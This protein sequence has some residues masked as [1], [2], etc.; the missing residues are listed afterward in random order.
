MIHFDVWIVLPDGGTALAGELVCGDA[1]SAGRF[2][3]EF[4]YAADWLESPAFPLDPISLP[5]RSGPFQANKLEPPL[6]VFED[7]LPDDWGRQLIIR[8]CN[9]LAVNRA[10]PTCCARWQSTGS[11]LAPCASPNMGI[12]AQSK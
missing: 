10:N 4:E 8:S 5:L 7:A 6:S 3:S 12:A 1:D 11:R 2:Q 9:F